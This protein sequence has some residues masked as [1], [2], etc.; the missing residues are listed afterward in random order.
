MTISSKYH[1]LCRQ[2]LNL[3]LSIRFAGIATSN[4]KILATLY[5]KGVQPLLSPQESELAIMQSVIRMGIRRTFEQK[6][7]KT[8]Y[9][10]AVYEKVKRATISLFSGEEGIDK[11]NDSYL[12]V[13]FE[14]EANAESII[15][16]K[17]LPLLRGKIG[18]GLAMA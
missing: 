1:D 16:G 8:I 4:G 15:N 11:Y 9:A 13:S 2:V 12:I 6:L 18:K 10:M 7:G 3:D 5:R 14:K 17:I